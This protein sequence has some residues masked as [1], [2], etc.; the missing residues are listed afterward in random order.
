M[1]KTHR[2]AK[3]SFLAL[4]ASIPSGLSLAAGEVSTAI[5]E[6]MDWAQFLSRHDMVWNRLP[7]GWHEAPWCGNGLIGS[8]IWQDETNNR[9][10]MQ[11][12]RSDVQEHRPMTQGHAGYT[13]TRLQIGSFYIE[14]VGKLEGCDLR[15][16]YHNAELRGTV[17]TSKGAI[18]LRHLV[19][20][21]DMVLLTELTLSGEESGV[22]WRW[23]PA[24]AWPTRGGAPANRELLK[25]AQERYQSKYP[26][27]IFDPNPKPYVTRI[28]G[29]DVCVQTLKHGGQHATAWTVLE[30]A[31]N[32]QIHIAS[33]GCRWPDRDP[34]A[35]IDAVAAV[36]GVAGAKDLAAWRQA[37][38]DWWHAYYS[39]SFVSLPDTRF[40][41]VYWTQMYKLGSATRA[42]RPMIDTAGIW[43]T[44]SRW[45]FVTWDFNVQYCYYPM[46]TAN[47]LR[48]AMSLVNTI[49]KYRDNLIKNVRPIE[50][51]E[52]S[53]YLSIN[54]GLDLYQPKDIDCRSFQNTGGH[55]VWAMHACWLVYRYS[56][57][58]RV[59]RQTIY[60]TLRRAVNYQLHLLEERDGRY[61]MPV[62]HS[63]EYGDAPD[64]N[65]ELA[66]LRW[67]CRALLR[68]SERLQI[69]DPLRRRWKD[70]LDRLVEYPKDETGFMVGRGVPFAKPHRHF[71][72]FMMLHPLYLVT[73][74]EP[75]TRELARKTLDH[76]LTINEEDFKK[77]ANWGGLASFTHTSASMTYAAIGDGNNALEQLERFLDNPV[78][79]RNSM[80]AYNGANPCLE[81]PLS[82]AHCIHEMLLQSWGDKIRVFPAVPDAWEDVVFRDL[83]AEG[84]FLLSAVRKRGKTRWIRIESLSGEPCRVLAQFDEDPRILADRPLS[85]EKV[86]ENVWDLPL[87][88]GESAILY[89]GEDPDL[90]IRP[91]PAE[92]EQLNWYGVR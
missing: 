84:A 45:P 13:R 40:E 54:T 21:R 86:A 57:D 1:S 33:I 2:A 68:A 87:R 4:V 5:R 70:V 62:T 92:Q 51:Q 56:M 43:Q 44:P 64:C 29:T 28:D 11:V 73:V 10:R 90:T 27:E 17:R 41:T 46:T 53:A 66:L 65:Y 67:G 38:Y 19:H 48:L 32:H 35:A 69:D 25:K 7:G 37:H 22:N 78:H 76:W 30:P 55:L 20:A 39:A 18:E 83:R 81:T 50:W 60:P 58:E 71:S 42:D 77:K 36:R 89:A 82:A 88:K 75:G 24:D 26:T 23:E 52:D 85:P 12:F 59:L 15:L 74:E 61:H 14:P 80:D 31:R 72:H 3:I 63:P 34:V 9:L 91:L 8:M 16:D 6:E 47:R 49:D 79:Q